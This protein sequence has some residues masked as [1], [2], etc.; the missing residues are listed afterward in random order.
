[1]DDVSDNMLKHKFCHALL[2]LVYGMCMGRRYKLDLSEYKGASKVVVAILSVI[3]RIFPVKTLVHWY[4]AISKMERGQIKK[5]KRCYYSNCLFPDLGKIYQAKWFDHAVDLE[6]D[7]EKFHLSGRY[8][9]AR[10]VLCWR[11]QHPT[12]SGRQRACSL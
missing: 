11:L 9:E 8:L 6:V 1:M 10:T 3:G 2:I 4:D 12:A 7:G 5:H